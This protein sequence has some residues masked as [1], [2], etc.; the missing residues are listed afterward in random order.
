MK[1]G[2]GTTKGA[3][4]CRKLLAH[5]SSETIGARARSLTILDFTLAMPTAVH[6]VTWVELTT[7]PGEAIGA[8]ALALAAVDGARPMA[9]AVVT[10]AVGV[11]RIIFAHLSRVA[12][13]AAAI[14]CRR[15]PVVR[16][17]LPSLPTKIF[18]RPSVL[19]CFDAGQAAQRAEV[20][21]PYD[22]TDFV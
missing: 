5:L 2:A 16:M 4:W 21:V 8:R 15:R 17:F 13:R 20:A 14:E 9:A 1:S 18:A 6:A 10:I 7:L 22:V 19:P 12:I 3:C 11:T